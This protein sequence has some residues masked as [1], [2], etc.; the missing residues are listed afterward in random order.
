MK[1]EYL[2]PIVEEI[3]IKNNVALL[4]ISGGSTGIDYGGVDISGDIE[5]SARELDELFEDLDE[6]NEFLSE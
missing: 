6:S 1:K 2:S 5:P 3:V 4:T